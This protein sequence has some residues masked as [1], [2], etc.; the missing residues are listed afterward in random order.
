MLRLLVL[1]LAGAP[2]VLVAAQQLGGAGPWWLEL[3][4]YLPYPLLLLPSIVAL[5]LALRLPMRW[6]AAPVAALALTASVGMGLAWHPAKPGDG[7]VRV[8]TYN[9]KV[10][11]AMARPG[12]VEALAREV[13]RHHP[14]VVV[15]QDAG[16]LMHGRVSGVGPPLFGLPEIYG[17]GQYVFASRLPLHDCTSGQADTR[18]EPFHYARCSVGV[19]PA[20]F[21]LVTAHFESPRTGLNAARHEGVDGIE[22]WRRNQA[23][24]LAQ[25]R[26]LA[27]A[28]AGNTGAL[29]LAGDLNAPESSEVVGNLLGIGL[30]DAFS[31][32]GR[33]YGYTYG[34]TL[35]PAVSFLRIDHIL[36][37]PAIG[38]VDCFAGGDDASD[39]RPVIADLL[40]GRPGSD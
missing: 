6:L 2:G 27:Q 35:R 28:L 12:G 3:S 10:M 15:M 38:V 9:A 18:G 40:P 17:A 19:G 36:V 14:D 34:H 4:R 7:A 20:A 37:G 23:D 13:A 11:N 29:V 22:S 31:T 5:V 39:H 32:A 30:R 25:S 24:R 1:L 33:G 8:M 21:V 26:G 16:R